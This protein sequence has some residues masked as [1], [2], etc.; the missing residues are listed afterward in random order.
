MPGHFLRFKLEPR[1]RRFNEFKEISAFMNQGFISHEI[2]M[3]QLISILQ[4]LTVLPET[5]GVEGVR[6]VLCI[7]LINSK[8]RSP[9]IFEWVKR[10]ELITRD[11]KSFINPFGELSP[12]F[13]HSLL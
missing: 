10:P 3:Q 2:I 9:K 7:R 1:L 13:I 12:S 11:Q 8:I 4:T 5:A 6:F